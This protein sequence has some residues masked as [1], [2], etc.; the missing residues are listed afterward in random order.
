MIFDVMK[1]RK[2]LR[3]EASLGCALAIITQKAWHP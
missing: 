3:D 2:I 1:G